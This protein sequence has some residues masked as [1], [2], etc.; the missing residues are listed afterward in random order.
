MGFFFR[1]FWILWRNST[2]GSFCLVK[3]FSGSVKD[4]PKTAS[5]AET[6]EYSLG[7]LRRPSITRGRYET[8]LNLH[9]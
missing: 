5:A 3:N 6:A 4:E 7:T 1:I 8:N 9:I 2:K